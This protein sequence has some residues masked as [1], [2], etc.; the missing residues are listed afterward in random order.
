MSASARPLSSCQAWASLAA[1]K[2][3]L[4]NEPADAEARRVRLEGGAARADELKQIYEMQ[5]VTHKEGRRRRA[6]P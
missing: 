6:T 1:G 3:L 5:V 4:V 2:H